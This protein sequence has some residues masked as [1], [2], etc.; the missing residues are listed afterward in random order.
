MS[1]P[2]TSTR[3]YAYVADDS[4]DHQLHATGA[5]TLSTT[6]DTGSETYSLDEHALETSHRDESA[7]FLDG[8]ATTTSA[9]TR[10]VPPS[11]R[12]LGRLGCR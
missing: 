10:R 6:T 2:V 7:D 5:A 4:R 9:Q 12:D 3:H 1:G 8:T 11:G